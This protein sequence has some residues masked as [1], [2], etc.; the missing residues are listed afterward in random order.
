MEW[1]RKGSP[2]SK[3]FKTHL[4]AG[5][6]GASVVW[7]S[8][9]INVNSLSYGVKINEQYD[10]DLVCND[11]HQVVCKKRPRKLS[12]KIILLH[13]NACPYTAI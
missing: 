1:H 12:L 13:D 8:G 11:V 7:G 2:P 9:M 3:T 10:S 6:I 5:N 4:S